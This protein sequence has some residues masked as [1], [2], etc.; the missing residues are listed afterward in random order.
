MLK[1]EAAAE[2][3]RG[4]EGKGENPKKEK[5]EGGNWVKFRGPLQILQVPR[6]P[7]KKNDAKIQPEP[8]K[9]NKQPNIGPEVIRPIGTQ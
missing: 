2:E 3:G 4:G 7:T 5:A 6:R 1:E 8:A 9:E